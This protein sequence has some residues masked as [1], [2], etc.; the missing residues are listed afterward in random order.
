LS[1]YDAETTNRAARSD[2]T[3]ATTERRAP[4]DTTPVDRQQSAD[5]LTEAHGSEG[6][7]RSS[8]QTRADARWLL[9]LVA[10]GAVRSVR[11]RRSLHPLTPSRLWL[12]RCFAGVFVQPSVSAKYII[13]EDVH[14][15][16]QTW[17]N[18]KPSEKR[19]RTRRQGDDDQRRRGMGAQRTGGMGASLA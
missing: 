13:K 17:I 11:S 10:S 5:A 2:Q 3:E 9:V 14:Y 4:A 12:N 18:G 16:K 15:K 1:R 19:T 8:D 6:R 7:R